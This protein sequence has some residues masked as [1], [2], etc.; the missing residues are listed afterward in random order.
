MFFPL[1]LG[2]FSL[3]LGARQEHLN[4]LGKGL[5]TLSKLIDPILK[6]Q[7]R[8]HPQTALRAKGTAA[9]ASR[10]HVWIVELKA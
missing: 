1:P 4:R 8:A 6:G 7:E 9:A 5:V 2:P 10:F 3:F